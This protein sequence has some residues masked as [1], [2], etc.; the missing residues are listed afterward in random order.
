MSRKILVAILV[1]S[2]GVAVFAGYYGWSRWPASGVQIAVVAAAQPIPPYTL[3][4]A[5]MLTEREMPEALRREPVYLRASEVVGKMASVPIPARGLIYHDFAVPAED[6][7]LTSDP[8]LEVVSFPVR[9]EKAV[10]G[11]VRPGQRINIYRV[12]ISSQA[13]YVSPEQAL[14]SKAAEAQLLASKVLVVDV[15]TGQG[16]PPAGSSMAQDSRARSGPTTIISV[17]VKPEVA[18]A[19][20][21]LVGETRGPYDLW[22]TLSPLDAEEP[23]T[24][25][26]ASGEGGV[27]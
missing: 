22:V 4:T 17:A 3:I 26:S 20:I 14:S 15:R 7:R 11:Q 9:P 8:A 2:L 24:R 6:F 10:G 27:Q 18:R 13:T 19:I 23:P 25:A 16:E 12:A 21:A 1:I 5:D